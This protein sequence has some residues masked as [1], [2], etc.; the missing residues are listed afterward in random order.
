[1]AVYWRVFLV[2]GHGSEAMAGQ[3]LAVG[4]QDVLAHENQVAGATGHHVD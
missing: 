1:M 3:A 4:L 2:S